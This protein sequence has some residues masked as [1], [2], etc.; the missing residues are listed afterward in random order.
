MPQ[1]HRT[2]SQESVFAFL[3]DAATHGGVTVTRVDTHG[4]AVFLA[5]DRVFKV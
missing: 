2:Q 5:G 3:A 1:S 4:A